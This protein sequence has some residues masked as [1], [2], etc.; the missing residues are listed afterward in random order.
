MTSNIPPEVPPHKLSG[1]L[2]SLLG[3]PGF[4]EW[5]L[6]GLQRRARKLEVEL[7]GDLD[8]KDTIRKRAQYALLGELFREA[9]N[10]AAA[11]KNEA[12]KRAVAPPSRPGL[13]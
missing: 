7:T 11:L 8:E 12:D 5:F 4:K 9:E 1:L 10:Q 2:S 6:P 13:A 3:N